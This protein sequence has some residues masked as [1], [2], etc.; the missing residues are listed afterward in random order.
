M[1]YDDF[2]CSESSEDEPTAIIDQENVIEPPGSDLNF[3]DEYLTWLVSNEISRIAIE[4]AQQCE[5]MGLPWPNMSDVSGEPN[6]AASSLTIA[7]TMQYTGMCEEFTAPLLAHI[8]PSAWSDPVMTPVLLP[9]AST[10]DF[11][12]RQS[13][14]GHQIRFIM[15][16]MGSE[17]GDAEVPRQRRRAT[18][19]RARKACDLCYASRKKCKGSSPCS[20]CRRQ[21]LP[22]CTYNRP[23]LHTD[24]RL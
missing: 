9:N 13:H 3:S 5:A 24:P 16:S 21:G 1:I 18:G 6:Q 12:D 10:P 2:L 23:R 19:P 14:G 11:G 7:P 15:E 8:V 17:T 20:R 4:F 22:A